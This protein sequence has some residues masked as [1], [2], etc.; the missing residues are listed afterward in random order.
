M[1]KSSFYGTGT[2][3]PPWRMLLRI[4]TARPFYNS[5]PGVR[6]DQAYVFPSLTALLTSVK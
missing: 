3:D 2:L 4:E 5:P 6:R 1:K